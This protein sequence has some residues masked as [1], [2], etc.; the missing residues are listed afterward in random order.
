MHKIDN[1]ES[2]DASTNASCEEDIHKVGNIDLLV[3]PLLSNLAAC[4]IQLKVIKKTLINN[5]T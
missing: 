5:Y 1:Q 2:M 4:A 3:I